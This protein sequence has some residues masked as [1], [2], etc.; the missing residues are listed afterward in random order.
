MT[1]LL[2]DVGQLLIGYQMPDVALT[3]LGRLAETGSERYLL[4]QEELGYNHADVGAELLKSWELPASLWEPIECHH[5]PLRAT[6][7][8]VDTALVHIGNALA[9][10]LNLEASTF[11]PAEVARRMD[12]RAWA[13]CGQNPD[14]LEDVAATVCDQWFTVFEVIWPGSNLID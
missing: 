10:S 3:L 12:G 5:A 13:I 14:I 6:L 2:H 11:D 4:E 7:F 8:P 1:G 9:N